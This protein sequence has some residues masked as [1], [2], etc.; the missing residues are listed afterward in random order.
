MHG[1]TI[2][3]S[4]HD[5]NRSASGSPGGRELRRGVTV[6]LLLGGFRIPGLIEY[7]AT[8]DYVTFTIKKCQIRLL[9]SLDPETGGEVNGQ[10]RN[11]TPS[12]APPVVSRA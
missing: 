12:P 6:E 11:R 8:G 10:P 4:S 2:D 5:R 7:S 1:W 9:A 3:P